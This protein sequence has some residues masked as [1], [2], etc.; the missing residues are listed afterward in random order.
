MALIK[1][2]ECQKEISDSAVSCP[3]CGA[4]VQKVQP[5]KVQQKNIG[6]V[7]VILIIML[8]VLGLSAGLDHMKSKT[9]V[10]PRAERDIGLLQP[11]K[12]FLAEHPE[13]GKAQSTKP[14]PNWR[15]GQRQRVQFD[16]GRNLLFY[17]QDGKVTSVYEDTPSEGRVRVWGGQ[18]EPES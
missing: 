10:P 14:I 8:V 12:V 5:V 13:F 6:C 3:G 18:S 16:N 1:C 9:P 11:V 15:F 2:R 7:G 4:P 17:T